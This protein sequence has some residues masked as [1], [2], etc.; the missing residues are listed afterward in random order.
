[1]TTAAENKMALIHYALTTKEEGVMFRKLLLD[2]YFRSH[3]LFSS[4]LQHAIF[5]AIEV[6]L[7]HLEGEENILWGNLA[8]YYGDN[9]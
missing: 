1:M 5:E 6:N 9:V 2:F 7:H 3:E 8:R 4:V